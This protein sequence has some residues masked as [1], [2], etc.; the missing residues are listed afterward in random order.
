MHLAEK[1]VELN[2][3]VARGFRHIAWVVPLWIE[4]PA[5][6]LLVLGF[7]SLCF[8]F[9]TGKLRQEPALS[10][11]TIEPMHRDADLT[12]KVHQLVRDHLGLLMPA[13]RPRRSRLHPF[14]QS[15]HSLRIPANVV[16]RP[17]LQSKNSPLSRA[18]CFRSENYRGSGNLAD[19]SVLP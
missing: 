16:Q 17:A 5:T 18:S 7:R 4:P 12:L 6:S 13:D 2:P 19:L 15:A 11:L 1:L 8:F 14:E 3:M 9:D 10:L